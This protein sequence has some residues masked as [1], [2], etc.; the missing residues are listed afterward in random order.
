MVQAFSLNVQM[1]LVHLS[2]DT[3]KINLDDS[4]CLFTFTPPL[5]ISK[6]ELKEWIHESK[7]TV[8]IAI[9]GINRPGPGLSIPYAFCTDKPKVLEVQGGIDKLYICLYDKHGAL[10]NEGSWSMTLVT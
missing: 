4:Q 9:S 3:A 5:S 6:L 10:L 7:D 1:S 2:S 8:F